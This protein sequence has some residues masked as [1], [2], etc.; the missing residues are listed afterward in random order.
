MPAPPPEN[1]E[2]KAEEK[3]AGPSPGGVKAWLPLI[4]TVV[5]MP[6][7]AYVMTI[8]VLL[9][10]LQ[11]SLGS[12]PV[13]ARETGAEAAAEPDKSAAKDASKPKIKVPLSKVIVN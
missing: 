2:P 6:V 4:G 5:L 1:D 7:L 10:K 12:Q 3:P 11:H 8:Y 9:P 13:Q